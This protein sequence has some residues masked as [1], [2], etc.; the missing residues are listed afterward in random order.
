MYDSYVGAGGDFPDNDNKTGCTLA[1]SLWH[2]PD[3]GNPQ[4][5]SGVKSP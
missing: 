4:I 2:Q 3:A 5:H 1:A